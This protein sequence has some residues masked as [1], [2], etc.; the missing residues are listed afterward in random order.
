MRTHMYTDWP[1]IYSYAQLYDRLFANP[2]RN[3]RIN[4]TPSQSG[5][6]SPAYQDWQQQGLYMA[7]LLGLYEP[8][9]ITMTLE[10]ILGKFGP[11]LAKEQQ[12]VEAQKASRGKVKRWVWFSSKGPILPMRLS[13]S[14][15]IRHMKKCFVMCELVEEEDYLLKKDT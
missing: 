8:C 6:Y 11:S 9:R 13:Q 1:G 2:G 12:E 10:A 7:Q 14:L 4:D 15:W 5:Y 3:D